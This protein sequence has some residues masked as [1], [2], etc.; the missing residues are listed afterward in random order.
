MVKYL[1]LESMAWISLGRSH[2]VLASSIMLATSR[3]EAY[4]IKSSKQVNGADLILINDRVI[5]NTCKIC[6]AR[7]KREQ[8]TSNPIQNTWISTPFYHIECKFRQSHLLV[9]QYLNFFSTRFI[10]IC[11]RKIKMNA[12][13][14]FPYD[15][16]IGSTHKMLGHCVWQSFFS[17]NH[18]V[19][20]GSELY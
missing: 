16:I 13:L 4:K 3:S 18:R 20:M 1:W 6:S 19:L 15:L 8:H 7:R 14:H 9:F 11:P 10:F 5:S 17:I 2:L 12:I